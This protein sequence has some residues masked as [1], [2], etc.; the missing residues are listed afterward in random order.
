MP[1]M[2]EESTPGTPRMKLIF[3]LGKV[4]TLP[5]WILADSDSVRNLIDE[6]VYKPLPFQLPMR[7]PGDVRV[8]NENGE[9]FNL[10]G[11]TV[12]P[13]SLGSNL[14]WHEFGIVLNLPLE[15]LFDA[16]VLAQH[17]CSLYYLQNNKKRLQFGVQ[18]CEIC[19][20]YRNDPQVGTSIQMKFT[21]D[22]TKRRRNRLK[23]GYN[24]LATLLR[25]FVMN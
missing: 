3:V 25:S 1:A 22:N 6:V 15:V 4:Q 21:D 10:K 16:E 19:K 24:F 17:L 13:F 5:V 8:I 12:L 23:I 18:I 20:R 11:F 14:I 7:S 2:S 9:A